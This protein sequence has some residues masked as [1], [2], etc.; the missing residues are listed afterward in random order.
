MTASKTSMTRRDDNVVRHRLHGFREKF[1]P[2]T[3]QSHSVVYP[4]SDR[5]LR[6]LGRVYLVSF[7][8]L[9]LN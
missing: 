6:R 9:K 4:Q 2:Y 3:L 1:S 8:S 7:Q 5:G